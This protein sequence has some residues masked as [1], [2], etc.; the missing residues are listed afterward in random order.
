[1]KGRFG[2]GLKGGIEIFMEGGLG[3]LGAGVRLEMF[4]IPPLYCTCF[5]SRGDVYSNT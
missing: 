3:L 5:L 4:E 2:E 1:M